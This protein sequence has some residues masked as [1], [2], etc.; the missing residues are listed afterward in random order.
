MPAAAPRPPAGLAVR[1]PRCGS[2][3][4]VAVED[5]LGPV[6]YCPY[7]GLRIGPGGPAPWVTDG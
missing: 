6:Y 4:E 7:C 3:M 2:R 5:C 1:C